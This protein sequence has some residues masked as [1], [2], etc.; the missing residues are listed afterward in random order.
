MSNFKFHKENFFKLQPVN[1]LSF[2]A[3]YVK[4]LEKEVQNLKAKNRKL[5]ETLSDGGRLSVAKEKDKELE[6]AGNNML[7]KAHVEQLNDVIG[8]LRSEKVEMAAQLR[9]MQTR[10]HHLET[11]SEQTAK[12]VQTTSE[13]SMCLCETI[14][15]CKWYFQVHV[16][17][18]TEIFRNQSNE[19][20]SFLCGLFNA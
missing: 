10:L 20:N 8:T 12:Q 5:E 15:C 19:S 11:H 13:A 14:W 9:K 3:E 4:N 18:T 6:K 1:L 16:Q 7:V 17:L 2:I